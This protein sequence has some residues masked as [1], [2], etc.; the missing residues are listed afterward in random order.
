MPHFVGPIPTV[1]DILE[2]DLTKLSL[3]YWASGPQ[4]RKPFDP[5]VIQQIYNKELSV[6]A[7]NRVILLELSNYLEGYRISSRFLF[8]SGIS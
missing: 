2:D 7:S 5:V 6:Q 8:F 3:Q 4:E 1:K